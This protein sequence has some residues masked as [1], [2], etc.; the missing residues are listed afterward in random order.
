MGVNINYDKSSLSRLQE[1]IN[2]NTATKEDYETLNTLMSNLGYKDFVKQRFDEEGIYDYAV[3][4]A[5][6]NR[7]RQSRDIMKEFKILGFLRGV[8]NFI[9]EKV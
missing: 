8:I 1:S 7:T 4:I 9:M 3:F 5:M 6:R 2:E